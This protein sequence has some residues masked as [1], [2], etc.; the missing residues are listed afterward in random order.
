MNEEKL[1][2]IILTRGGAERFLELLCEIKNIEIVGVFV[3]TATEK[4]RPLLA[5]IKR[6]IRY[7]GYFSTVN[8][9]VTT[10]WATNGDK[11]GA[12]ES[13]ATSQNDLVKC[14]ERLNIPLTKVANYHSEEAIKL[15][16]EANA[17]LG[18]LYGT[19]IVN[20]SVFSIPRLGSI[21]IHQ[22]LAPLY[23]GGPPVFW[24]L[25]NDEN[26]I[27]ITVH[28]VAS[29]VDAGDIIVQTKV[30]LDYDFSRYALD[31]E[32]FLRDYRASLKEPSAQLL[33]EAVR[34]IAEGKE[35]RTTQDTTI[36]KRYKLPIK[37][38]KNELLRV[39]RKRQKAQ[40]FTQKR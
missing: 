35:Q 4:R 22:G 6:S 32:D 2:L 18:I 23:R 28:F 27:G 37:S 25:F 33:I 9:F 1:K 13:I 17:D 11:I 30:P 29:N 3:E 19:N 12:S 24:E 36:G 14:A 15:L 31:Y 5:K 10:F 34:Q 20:E 7:D 40:I 16:R 21:N 8:K 39:L 38:E 26:Q